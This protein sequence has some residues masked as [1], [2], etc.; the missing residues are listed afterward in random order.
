MTGIVTVY[1]APVKADTTVNVTG[2]VVPIKED[3]GS[4]KAWL[5]AIIAAKLALL[6]VIVSAGLARNEVRLIVLYMLAG[7]VIAVG[8]ADAE[9]DDVAVAP[10][11]ELEAT[12]LKSMTTV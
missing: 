4:S 11:E 2:T 3:G 6:E 1:V 10:T 5:P 8:T 9:R 7:I 12:T